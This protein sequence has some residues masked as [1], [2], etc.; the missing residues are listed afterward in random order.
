MQFDLTQSERIENDR[1]E[2]RRRLGR[3]YSERLMPAVY[4]AAV[5][6][7]VRRWDVPGEPVPVGEAL[8]ATY[9]TAE[10][11]D[12]WG[13]AW[14][15]TW[16]EL[17]GTVPADWL[18]KLVEG[19]VDLGFTGVGPGFTAEGLVYSS[20]GI[21]VKGLHPYNRWFP[22]DAGATD[23]RVFVEAAANP[24][25]EALVPTVAGDVETAAPEPIYG[26]GGAQL[27]LVDPDVRKLVADLDVL[28]QLA[29]QLPAA[30]PRGAQLWA[31][32]SDALDR[33]NLRDISGSAAAAREV[34]APLLARRANASAHRI[35]AV[36]HAHIDSA[37]LW[38][39]R[40][41][42]R[43]VARTCSS[44]TQ[45]MDDYPELIF[46]MSQAQ[47]FAW[48]EDQH[49]AVVGSRALDE[50]ARGIG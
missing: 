1:T 37:W 44:V 45:L 47:Q 26:W 46:A 15:T 12:R 39:L 9:R 21:P 27:A 23:V 35:S 29:A 19:V 40:E 10:V 34:L 14:G 49:P 33:L 20:D 48:I 41:T 6:L 7:T 8:A 28:G 25:F 11:G 5:P 43:K 16:F 13:P 31:G 3:V 17:T 2:I 30:D 36:G 22:V 24:T 42:I 4:Q 18:G 38:P 50:L 32:I